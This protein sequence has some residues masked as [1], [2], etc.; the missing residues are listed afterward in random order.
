MDPVKVLNETVPYLT[1]PSGM[2]ITR[3]VQAALPAELHETIVKQAP[4]AQIAYAEAPISVSVGA[5]FDESRI[6]ELDQSAQNELGLIAIEAFRTRLDLLNN[7]AQ[8]EIFQSRWSFVLHCV[9]LTLSCVAILG[10]VGLLWF[11]QLEAGA[12]ATV[13]SG[14]SGW[15]SQGPFKFY[16][17][18][19]KRGSSSLRDI[20]LIKAGLEKLGHSA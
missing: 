6:A 20:E 2:D 14:L 10:S 18:A 17:E 11:G 3:M 7:D 15:L 12:V 16:V 13:T 19:K 9:F 5:R 4:S 1:T 8:Q